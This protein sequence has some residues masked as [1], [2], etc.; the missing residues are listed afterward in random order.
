MRFRLGWIGAV[1]GAIVLAA[2]TALGLWA[3]AFADRHTRVLL[4]DD[5]ALTPPGA[6]LAAKVAG[7]AG[8]WGGDRWDGGALPQALA[9]ERIAPDGTA[10]VV[11]A[12]GANL[13]A[14]RTQ[15]WR[16]LSARISDDGH[17]IFG[18]PDDH[19]AD[20]SLAADGRLIGRD[21]DQTDW[22]SYILLRRAA[23]RN[24]AAAIADATERSDPLWR[25]VEIPERSQVG[26]AAGQRITLRAAVYR[27]AS[28]G[29]QPLV[30]INH[31]STA[32][33]DPER[34]L[35]FEEQAR[36][37]LSLGY[38]VAVPMR[39]G[40]GRSG[41]PMLESDDFQT[42]PPRVQID[43]G[44]ED[45]DAVVDYF[46]AQPSVDPSR[47]VLAG[48]EHGGLLSVVYAARHPGKVSAVLN[49]SGGWWPETYRVGAI[50]TGEFADA[51]GTAR[52]PM[53]WLYAE[54]DAFTP[55]SHVEEELA[56]FRASGGRA[57]L[58]VA[59]DPRDVKAY[60]TRLFQWTAKWEGAVR[61]FLAG[62]DRPPDGA[63]LTM[64]DFK[65]PIDPEAGMDG[66][67]FYPT[68]SAPG[69]A[70]NGL[71]TVDALRD[72]P[73]A[74]GRFPLILLSHGDGGHRLSHHDLATYLA[75]HGYVVVAVTHPGD[76]DRDPTAWRT[77]RVLVG[78]E[79]DLRAAL[80]AVL[81]DPVFGAHV[82]RDRIGVAGFSLGGYTALLLAGAVPDLARFSTYCRDTGAAPAT[83]TDRPPVIRPG[84]GFFRD[85]RI[86][87]AYL[88]AP[89][90]GYLFTRDGLADVTIPIH[91][92][93]AAEDEV[94]A[95][96][97]AG[98]RI[99]DLLPRPPEYVLVPG[100][101]H[102]AYLA[103]CPETLRQQTPRLCTDPP[104]IARAAF[105][106]ELG[107]EMMEF[108]QRALA[109]P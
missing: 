77:D 75:R 59:P 1:A 24:R 5:L 30:I 70:R 80:D 76:S 49:F 7:L 72:A 20:F 99:R 62:D 79:Y 57:R 56:A 52:A 10:S 94:L 67:I 35:R 90:P 55:L 33:I 37:F 103:P 48:E 22:R 74:D 8:L 105:H 16:R 108:F 6:D 84:L 36:Y 45:I 63:G 43:S 82:D 68:W 14:H 101:G 2:L 83:C 65:D 69:D 11:Y 66:A 87:A 97:Y 9:V 21:T 96:P 34:T 19:I 93:D 13:D 50:N 53:L 15:G 54:G 4:P 91:I 17:L 88:M 61:A 98:E 47:I 3:L 89:G 51:G 104:G 92:D 31:G 81:A 38:A 102:Y 95:R 73:P 46:I 42:P 106:A 109:S 60:G 78:R 64:V 32:G 41:G 18:L 44:V 58:V 29:R 23:G 71:W 100:V 12:W 28:P 26:A 40:R 27:G 85:E 25:E 39:K 107:A 86:K